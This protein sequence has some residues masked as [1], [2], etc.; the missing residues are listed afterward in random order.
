MSKITNIGVLDTRDIKEELAKELTEITNIEVIIESPE[1]QLL[2]KNCKKANVGS[3]IKTY[4]DM[5]LISYSGELKIDEEYLQGLIIAV[6]LI[7]DGTVVFDDD[8]NGDLIEEKIHTLVVNG[9]IICSK[10]LAGIIQLRT[11]IQGEMLIY[12]SGYTF[13]NDSTE[14]IN[15]FLACLEEHSKLAFNEL[16]IS[17]DI[18]MDLFRDKISKI[19]VLN[20]LIIREE[21]QSSFARYIQDYFSLNKS[22]IPKDSI[23]ISGDLYI[24][25]S[26]INKY[27]NS[28]L[29]VEG[30][31]E[32]SLNKASNIKDHIKALYCEKVTC[33]YK[34]YESVKNIL[35]SGDI[36]GVKGKLLKNTG[37]LTLSKDFE[38][39]SKEITIENMG[40][41]V[42]EE[43]IDV[44]IFKEKV[45][46]ITNYG[47][48]L[49]PESVMNIV[50]SK[51]KENY[52]KVGS[53]EKRAKENNDENNCLYA[54]VRELKL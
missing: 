9:E 25:D 34:H 2:L 26:I 1:S 19:Q 20:K 16:L 15:G 50:K 28:I 54:N 27:N 38:K 53:L 46:E 23:Y 31:V 11:S 36:Q 22:V 18:D 12:N 39:D 17:E 52:G 30:K 10:R 4:K 5:P 33:S 3:T 14:L 21:H 41:I 6:V 24:D 51:L 7:V 40:K 8:I 49:A 35:L 42:I 47:L 45:A 48:I 44:E 29:F 43:D 37:Y 32:I 13:F